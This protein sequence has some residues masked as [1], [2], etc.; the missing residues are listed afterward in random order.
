VYRSIQN[1]WTNFRNEFPTTQQ[2]KMFS[3]QLINCLTDEVTFGGD[4]ITD[5]HNQY[6][7]AEEN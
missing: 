7:Q 5:L 1:A 2:G 3:K 6:Q 4:G